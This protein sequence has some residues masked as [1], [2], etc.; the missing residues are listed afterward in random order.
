M[1]TLHGDTNGD[2]V[3]DVTLTATTDANGNYTFDN[4]K[5]GA[6]TTDETM[7]SGWFQVS[8]S[9]PV[10]LTSGEHD[11]SGND[12]VNTELG[13]IHGFKFEDMDANGK[14]DGSDTPMAGITI[15]LVG[16]VDGNGTVDTV[17]TTTD[18]NGYFSFENLR[19][20]TYTVSELFTD[21][22]TWGATVDHNKDGIGDATTT[23]TV[24]SGQ[25]LVAVS[26]EE[27]PLGTHTEVNVGDALTFGNH[28]LGALGLTPGFWY[29]HEYVWDA[30]I[31]GTDTSNGGVDGKGVSLASKLAAAGTI[32]APDIAN[33]LPGN[34][35][36]DHDGHKDLLFTDASGKQLVIEWDDAREIVGGANGTGGD[37][38]GDFVRYAITT[39]LNEYGV[40]NFSAPAGMNAN[41]TDWLIANGGVTHTDF[42]GDGQITNADPYILNY[43]NATEPGKDGFTK[44]VKASSAAWQNTVNGVP[45]GSQIFADMNATTDGATG[46]NMMLSLNQS[47]VLTTQDEG[48][49][50]GI[51]SSVLNYSGS[52]LQL[53]V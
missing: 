46:N 48:D 50:F 29:N 34:F 20:G 27:G 3:V 26:G 28:K 52:Y 24:L 45:S 30:P 33:N 37:K 43:N 9:S 2:G 17:T 21:G 31:L 13:S 18:A 19:P 10:T 5:P 12:F 47:N 39:L 8:G 23:V 44:T 42:N 4:L 22:T 35:D 32:S 41:I 16:D 38:L 36:V 7:Q 40:P 53:H 49:H 1:I 14:F 15:Q 25:E 51:I 11:T 6:Y